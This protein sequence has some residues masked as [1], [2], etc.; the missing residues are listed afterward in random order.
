M[1]FRIKYP[2]KYQ[3]KHNMCDY[4]TFD[5]EFEL[6]IKNSFKPKFASVKPIVLASETSQFITFEQV[7]EYYEKETR[8]KMEKQAHDDAIAKNKKDVADREAC[9]R[10]Q[11]EKVLPTPVKK[12]EYSQVPP[13][14][15]KKHEYTRVPPTPVKH[16]SYTRVPPT[17]VKKYEYARVPPTPVKIS[18]DKPIS[19]KISGIIRPK[20]NESQDGW[21]TVFR[22][23]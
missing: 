3:N 10:K 21:N 18:L 11:V 20:K 22:R 4:I 7:V 19:N 16:H 12:H 6:E 2:D 17:P 13:T 8:R 14:P 9:H 1:N 5:S 15:V 23:K